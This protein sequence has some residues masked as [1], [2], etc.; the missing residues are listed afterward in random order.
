MLWFGTDCLFSLQ[1][2]LVIYS[3]K[4]HNVIIKNKLKIK[5]VA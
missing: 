4:T 1:M 3:Y 2:E 5:I